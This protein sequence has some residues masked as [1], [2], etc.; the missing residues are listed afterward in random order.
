MGKICT[1]TKSLTLIFLFIIM[2]N[3]GCAFIPGQVNKWKKDLPP[4]MQKNIG[5]TTVEYSR[6]W[7]VNKQGRVFYFDLSIHLH[8]FA[9][10]R[11]F[12]HE[13]MHSFEATKFVEPTIEWDRFAFEYIDI[14]Y[15]DTFPIYYQVLPLTIIPAKDVPNAYALQDHWENT[16]ETFVYWYKGKKSKSEIVTKNMVTIEK[17]VNGEY[18]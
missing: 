17:F 10:K 13:A 12:L 7:D 4:Y 1:R 6:F 11:V 14:K 5:E 15:Q 8:P 3:A 2:F 9:S 18:E 16:A